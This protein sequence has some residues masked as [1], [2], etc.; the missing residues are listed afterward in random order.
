MK[1]IRCAPYHPASNVLAEWFVQTFK[2]C[3]KAG[4][5]D[6]PLNQCL[7]VFPL[8]YR[9]TPH[10]TTNVSYSSLFLRRE[11]RTH[12]DLLHPSVERDVASKSETQS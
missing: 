3:M 7:T 5:Q 8:S 9:S 10:S 6:L 2:R 1:H 4:D 12:L 11:L